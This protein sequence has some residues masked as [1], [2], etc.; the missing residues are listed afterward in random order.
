MS[1]LRNIGGHGEAG[2]EQSRVVGLRLPVVCGETRGEVCAKA[3]RVVTDGI[4][5]SFEAPQGRRG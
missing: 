2:S 5:Q 3:R 1:F 4:G